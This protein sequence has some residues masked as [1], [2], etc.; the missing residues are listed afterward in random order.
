MANLLVDNIS[1]S[2][3]NNT[4]FYLR[5]GCPEFCLYVL[6]LSAAHATLLGEV[7]QISGWDRE[8]HEAS[9]LR[10]KFTCGFPFTGIPS[11]HNEA[12]FLFKDKIFC[13]YMWQIFHFLTSTTVI[14]IQ[15][16]AAGFLLMLLF[17]R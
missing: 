9:V 15:S 1:A 3:T 10:W 8:E 6:Q 7:P 2:C 13:A 5:M 11:A 14:F 12:D 4:H 16:L 17:S